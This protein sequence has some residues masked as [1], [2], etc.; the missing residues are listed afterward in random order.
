MI[1]YDYFRS[2]ASHRVRIA[3]NLK[4]LK[5]ERKSIHLRKGEQRG[6]EYRAVNAQGLVPTLEIGGLRLTQSLA[7][8]EYLDEKYPDPPLVPRDAEDR[9]FARSIAMAIA[10]D[11]HPIDNTRVISPEQ[12]WAST[13]QS[14]TPGGA[15][16]PPGVE[17][18]GSVRSGRRRPSHAARNRRSRT[19]ASCRRCERRARK[20]MDPIRASARSTLARA[21]RPRR[22]AAWGAA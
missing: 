1:L 18:I 10:C 12:S 19:S 2:S 6:A 5:A 17:A 16:D 8:I 3:L 9:A 21:G 13:R 15:P 20:L 14:A 7:I 11:I 4:G 22:R